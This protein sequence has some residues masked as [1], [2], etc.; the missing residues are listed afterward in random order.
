MHKRHYIK[1][2]RGSRI[3]LSQLGPLSEA[4]IRAEVSAHPRTATDALAK[5][6]VE[7]LPDSPVEWLWWPVFALWAF[8]PSTLTPSINVG[9]LYLTL[10]DLILLLAAIISLPWAFLCRERCKWAFRCTFLPFTGFI[11]YALATAF[12]SH[13]YRA[14]DFPYIISPAIEAWSA[15]ALA[16]G[17]VRS[18]PPEKLHAF[19]HRLVVGVGAVGVVYSG[20]LLFPVQWVRA[21]FAPDPLSGMQRLGGPL[22]AATLMPAVFVVSLPF[23]VQR[24]RR[25]IGS[26]STAALAGVLAAAVVF[27]GSRAAVLSLFALLTLTMVRRVSLKQKALLFAVVAAASVFVFQ[28]ASP[29]RFLDLSETYRTESYVSSIR[30]WTANLR[31][32][33]FGH[34]LGQMWPWY[35]YDAGFAGGAGYG[36]LLS[37]QFGR[38]L[39][40][41]HSTFLYVLVETGLVGMAL[42]GTS[43]ALPLLRAYRGRPGLSVPGRLAPGLLASLVIFTFDTMLLRAFEL[44]AIW[45]VFLFLVSADYPSESG[46]ARESERQS[47]LSL[48]PRVRPALLRARGCGTAGGAE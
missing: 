8:L 24:I 10:K 28:Y 17:L 2:N 34:G 44:A 41:P 11:V 5:R 43:V 42:F 40:H 14:Y 23:L 37:T 46:T 7:S 4:P 47:R 38:V 25:T 1:N 9:W 31:V 15:M 45:W 12:A 21:G 19:A 16:L 29:S 3:S 35:L 27:S 26:I 39:Y 13:D 33:V 30:A 22:G 36:K 20:I 6:V 32:F 18:L 48:A